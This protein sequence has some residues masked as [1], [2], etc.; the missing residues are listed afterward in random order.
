MD[1]LI[2]EENIW[3][4]FVTQAPTAFSVD[5]NSAPT[6]SFTGQL[7]VSLTDV[8]EGTWK[9]DFGKYV[10]DIDN[11]DIF[12]VVALGAASSHLAVNNAGI[13]SY[14]GGV[15]VEENTF[16]MSLLLTDSKG[17][18]TEGEF[19]VVFRT[20]PCLTSNIQA[21]AIEDFYFPN[22]VSSFKIEPFQYTLRDDD[23]C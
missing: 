12:I 13:L 11:D 18:E 21:Q 23:E 10:S 7:I 1:K 16:K 22:K 5:T 4:L 19:E 17:A 14:L 20:E 3:T 9:F 2:H 8:K 15:D 6:W